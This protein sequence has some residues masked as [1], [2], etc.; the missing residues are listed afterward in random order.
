MLNKEGFLLGVSSVSGIFINGLSK[1]FLI[2]IA[3]SFSKPSLFSK[4]QCYFS[5]FVSLSLP[6]FF[7]ISVVIS[8][9]F[10]C[11]LGELAT[12]IISVTACLVTET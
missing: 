12:S 1:E 4:D 2:L 10:I 8:F 9:S 7:T 6:L 3:E 11:V 5:M